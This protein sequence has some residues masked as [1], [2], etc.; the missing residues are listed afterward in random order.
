MSKSLGNGIDPLD[1]VRLFG[2][3]AL[4]FTV[5]HGLSVGTDIILDPD[6]LP[7]SFAPGRNFANKLW[8]MG[9]LVLQLTADKTVRALHEV[10]PD[11]LQ[12]ADR[13]ILSRMER[14]VREATAHM[15]KFRLNDAAGAPYHFLWDD[16]ADWYLEAIKPR[17]YGDKGAQGGDVALAVAVQCFRTALKLLHPTMPFITEELYRRLPGSARSIVTAPWPQPA[18][19]DDAEAE[20]AFTFLQAVVNQTREIRARF[21]IKPSQLV[22]IAVLSLSDGTAAELRQAEKGIMWLARVAAIRKTRSGVG[23]TAVLPEGAT[24][25]VELGEA[26]DIAKQCARLKD[27]HDRLDRQLAGLRGKL[28]NQGFLA[29]APAAVVEGER[30]KERE[31]GERLERL[32]RTLAE[33]GC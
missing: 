20:R 8:N 4:R 7:T 30:A 14:C 6:D 31:W 9:R 32:G 26:A 2:A 28:A 11:E 12:L 3:D 10:R 17:V 13:W 18:R 24:L 33:L 15:E 19:R 23:V 22:N 21:E 27:E 5:I 29:K 1:V 16:F 25:F